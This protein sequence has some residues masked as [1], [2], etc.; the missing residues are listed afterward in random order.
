MLTEAAQVDTVCRGC[1]QHLV[2]LALA[3]PKPI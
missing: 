3:L 1:T 2:R